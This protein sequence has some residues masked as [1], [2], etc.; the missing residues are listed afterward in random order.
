VDQKFFRKDRTAEGIAVHLACRFSKPNFNHL[1]G[2]IPFINGGADVEAFI[3]LQ[4]DKLAPQG[5]RQ[6]LG[7][8]SLANACF[9]FQKKWPPHFE[10]Q[11]NHSR[12][13]APCDIAGG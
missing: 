11:I 4:T 9:T 12:K 7:N 6:H 13:I 2:I 5:L 1:C 10:C 3:A 8:L